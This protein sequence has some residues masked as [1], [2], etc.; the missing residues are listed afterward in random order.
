MCSNFH[1]CLCTFVQAPRSSSQLTAQLIAALTNAF[2]IPFFLIAH[3][4]K[5]CQMIFSRSTEHIYNFF[6][7][8]M[9]SSCIL[10]NVRTASIVPLHG[11]KP[12]GVSSSVQFKKN[13]FS[14]TF[15]TILIACSYNSIP[16]Y[17]PQFM[18]SPFPS[19]I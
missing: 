6:C 12:N 14:S 16:L 15:S 2:G 4:T 1:L 7:L 13:L 10:L 3:S 18:I 19:K 8:A 17:M 11:I 9:F 5:L